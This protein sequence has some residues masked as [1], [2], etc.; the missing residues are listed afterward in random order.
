M[1]IYS[2]LDFKFPGKYNKSAGNDTVMG[3]FWFY[4]STILL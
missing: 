2:Y 1:L 4:F 3:Y